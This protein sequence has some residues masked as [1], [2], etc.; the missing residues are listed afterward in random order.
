[1][2][3]KGI[4]YNLTEQYYYLLFFFIVAIA[5]DVNSSTSATPLTVNS[6]LPEGKY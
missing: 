5:S 1:M 2:G 3:S 6:P 4:S